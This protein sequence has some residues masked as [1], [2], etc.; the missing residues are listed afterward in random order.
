VD[1][2]PIFREVFITL[3]KESKSPPSTTAKTVSTHV[4]FQHGEYH[5]RGISQCDIHHTFVDNI[6]NNS[7]FDRFIV[8]YSRPQNICD[9]LIDKICMMTTRLA[10]N[11]AIESS[12]WRMENNLDVG[13]VM[14]YVLYRLPIE[15]EFMDLDTFSR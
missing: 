1:I 2:I 4:L 11:R 9:A 7:G 14:G 12:Y 10:C 8:A 3:D 6:G 15:L 5:P 13:L